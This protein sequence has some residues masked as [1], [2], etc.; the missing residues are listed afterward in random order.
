MVLFG[1]NHLE[2]IYLDFDSIPPRMIIKCDTLIQISDTV[3][4]EY[5][6]KS[7]FFRFLI[8]SEVNVQTSCNGTTDVTFEK[9]KATYEIAIAQ[10]NYEGYYKAMIDSTYREWKSKSTELQNCFTN[11]SMNNYFLYQR[12]NYLFY[13]YPGNNWINSYYTIYTGD[14]FLKITFKHIDKSGYGGLSDF[15]SEL[16]YFDY[17][18]SHIEPGTK[19]T[20]LPI[21]FFYWYE[22]DRF[23]D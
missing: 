6:I 11:C 19:P 8:E 4:I 16:C 14:N 5:G 1:Q 18:D 13:N 23:K 2:S 17:G 20:I 9:A 12:G 21:D 7:P 15:L 3:Y 22:A 10:D